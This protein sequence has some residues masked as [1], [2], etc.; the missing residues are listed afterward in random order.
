MTEE[1]LIEAAQRRYS[2][3][4]HPGLDVMEAVDKVLAD[5]VNVSIRNKEIV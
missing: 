3:L 2:W 1:K 5:T 4:V